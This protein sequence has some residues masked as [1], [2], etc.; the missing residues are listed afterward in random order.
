MGGSI[1][2]KNSEAERLNARALESANAAGAASAAN[3][4]GALPFSFA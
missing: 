3:G 1:S 2:K 4:G